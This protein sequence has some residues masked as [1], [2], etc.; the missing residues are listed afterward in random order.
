MIRRPPRS[1]RTDTLFPYTT[2]FRSEMYERNHHHA[3][4]ARPRTDD[5]RDPARWAADLGVHRG[6]RLSGAEG[7]ADLCDLDSGGGSLDGAPALF[8]RI[9]DPRVSY[10]PDDRERGGHAGGDHLRAAGACHGDRESVV[11]GKGVLVSVDL[12]G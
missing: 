3:G 2:L 6:E 8:G 5:P 1:T 10:R 4:L 11:L 12:G 7:R 9:D